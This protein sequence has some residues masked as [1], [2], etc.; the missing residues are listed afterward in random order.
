MGCA[1]QRN[2]SG[3]RGYNA[4]FFEARITLQQKAKTSELRFDGGRIEK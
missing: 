2:V 3:A 4:P 1:M